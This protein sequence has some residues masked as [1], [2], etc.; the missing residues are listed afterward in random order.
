MPGQDEEEEMDF[1]GGH[2]PRSAAVDADVE[3]A[4]VEDTASS[5][6]EDEA[7]TEDDEDEVDDEIVLFGHR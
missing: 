4:D 1:W 2:S 6:S 7:M 3:L 5:S